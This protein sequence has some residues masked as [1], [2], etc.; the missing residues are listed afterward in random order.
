MINPIANYFE[1]KSYKYYYA[2]V[3][4][5]LSGGKDKKLEVLGEL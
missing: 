3:N 2:Y 5:L 4:S 1:D